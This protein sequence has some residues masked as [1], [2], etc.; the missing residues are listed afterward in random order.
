[1]GLL[2][3]NIDNSL[4][5]DSVKTALDEEVPMYGVL[6]EPNNTIGTRT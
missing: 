4:I 1:M 5:P 2:I 3:G 6:F